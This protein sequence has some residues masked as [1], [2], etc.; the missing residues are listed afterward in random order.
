[1]K[2]TY[3]DVYYKKCENMQRIQSKGSSGQLQCNISINLPKSE[4]QPLFS[5]FG[6]TSQNEFKCPPLDNIDAIGLAHTSF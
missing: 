5:F 1:M 3:S 6:V 2:C 4:K